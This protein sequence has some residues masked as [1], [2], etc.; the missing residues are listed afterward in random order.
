VTADGSFA[1][2]KRKASSASSDDSSDEETPI[3]AIDDGRMATPIDELVYGLEP[4][5]SRR[6]HDSKRSKASGNRKEMVKSKSTDKR[7]KAVPVVDLTDEHRT[8]A[9]QVV[10]LTEEHFNRPMENIR[11]ELDRRKAGLSPKKA[12]S[13]DKEMIEEEM[14]MRHEKSSQYS[15][16]RYVLSDP[17]ILGLKTTR[18]P[19]GWEFRRNSAGI[20]RN[21]GFRSFF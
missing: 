19:L 21:S 16:H 14:K 6:G 7:T 2:R 11:R 9:G 4:P 20:L 5:M 1:K 10:D 13:E 17:G 15:L 18:L 12:A 3:A 8:K